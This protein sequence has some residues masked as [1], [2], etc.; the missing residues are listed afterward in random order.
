MNVAGIE[1]LEYFI[2]ELGNEDVSHHGDLC[3]PRERLGRPKD[4]SVIR[5][6]DGLPLKVLRAGVILRLRVDI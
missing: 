1:V 3:D 6:R 2:H 4:S 5:S